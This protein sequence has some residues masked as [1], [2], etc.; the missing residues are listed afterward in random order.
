MGA[1]KGNIMIDNLQLELSLSRPSSPR[2]A[3]RNRVRE[4]RARWWFAEM[5]RVVRGAV[6]RAPVPPARP[7]QEC[8][9]FARLT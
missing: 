4:D 5:R 6:N 3:G 8:L 9:A 7:R 1:T 2:R